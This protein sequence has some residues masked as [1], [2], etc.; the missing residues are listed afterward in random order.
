MSRDETRITVNGIDKWYYKYRLAKMRPGKSDTNRNIKT[1]SRRRMY[2]SWLQNWKWL[3]TKFAIW[4]TESIRQHSCVEHFQSLLFLLDV[5]LIHHLSLY[6][7]FDMRMS[8]SDSVAIQK[9]IF[10]S[11]DFPDQH[12]HWWDSLCVWYRKIMLLWG[13]QIQFNTVPCHE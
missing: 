3:V 6:L 9:G 2:T 1:Q 8:K 4:L 7:I 5:R 11:R 12:N 13:N 10:E